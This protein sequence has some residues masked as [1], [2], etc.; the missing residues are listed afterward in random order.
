MTADTTIMRIQGTAYQCISMAVGTGSRCY[1]NAR[2]TKRC[3]RMQRLPGVRMT[4]STV[5]ASAEGRS[6]SAISRYK[7]TVCIMTAAAIG[8]CLR[9][10]TYQR[11]VMAVNAT[12]SC[13]YQRC[14]I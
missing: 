12:R 10:N 14:M 5:T 1:N 2:M 6:I 11:I 9:I 8:M 7:T 4:R 13:C 3:C